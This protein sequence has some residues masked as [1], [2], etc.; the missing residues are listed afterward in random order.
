MARPIWRCGCNRPGLRH[1]QRCEQ[2]LVCTTIQASVGHKMKD[3][4]LVVGHRRQQKGHNHSNSCWIIQLTFLWK[5]GYSETR[6][7]PGSQ[8]TSWWESKFWTSRGGRA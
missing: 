8:M 3:I 2:A 5:L 4:T 6:L 7:T 1:R